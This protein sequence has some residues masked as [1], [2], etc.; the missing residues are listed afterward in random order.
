MDS[1]Q[2]NSR[3]Y[4]RQAI[5]AEIKSLEESIQELK[6]RRNALAPVSSLPTEVIDAIFL[7]ARVTVSASSATPG[8]QPDP[9]A[10]LRVTH[11]CHRW[12]EIAINQ[13][14]F[15][16]HVNFATLSS[17]GTA[18]IVAR[19]KTAPLYLEAKLLGSN[20]D[21][22]RY[23]EFQ[24]ELQVC[25]SRTCH[26]LI[27]ANFWHLRKTLDSLVSPAHALER[28]SLY[29][30]RQILQP[31]LQPLQPDV[32]E[33]LFGGAMPR[34]SC[35][36][37]RNCNISW[38]SPLL[39]GL[40]IFEMRSPS[41]TVLP[42]LSVWL[43]AL[44]EMPQLKMLTLHEASPLAGSFP[45]DV[46]RTVKLPSL[47]HFDIADR[48]RDCASAL[49][50]LELPALTSLCVQT[51]SSRMDDDNAEEVLP[52]IA[53]HSH[54]QPLQSMLIRCKNRR[55]EFLAW[56]VLDID[57]EVHGELPTL[58]IAT[59]PAHVALS[60]TS[61]DWDDHD[62][63]LEFLGTV[64][65]AFPLDGLV[66]L[67]AQDFPSPPFEQFWHH[68]SLK[69][70][71]L[72]RV[73]LT[74]GV[75]TR[76][77]DW[78]LADRGGR[79]DPLL[80]SLKELVLVDAQLNEHRT[81]GLCDALMKRVEHGVPLEMLDLRTCSPD[82]DNPEAVRVLN[83]IVVDVRDPEETL[84]ARE[85]LIFMWDLN[86]GP[87]KDDNSRK[88]YQSETDDDEDDDEDANDDDNENYYDDDNDYY[89]DDD[90]DEDDDE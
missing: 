72:R 41:M 2:P 60:I 85:K 90:D 42:R 62:N 79:E 8:K 21:D 50:H 53:R 25:V 22:A 88:A 61:K 67:I 7:I 5:D 86:P 37:L 81:T 23:G 16:N 11:V 43:D 31:W 30:E 3:E 75:A 49:A 51:Y 77:T 18:E 28:L 54:T 45:F 82:P 64:M 65:A 9:L 6:Y 63:H 33:T 44:D 87:F 15:W 4:Q 70:P 66:T 69:W 34:L 29:S 10:W 89:D 14:L 71:L 73:R 12:R 20:W 76:F 80:P 55:M 26:L 46:E 35:L 17:A 48:P 83:E 13:P 56:P 58:P 47:T 19:A 52:Y 74:P 36:E 84:D 78:L 32:P 27:S 24:E 38:K 57:V 1:S 68:N 40:R 39:K 59:P